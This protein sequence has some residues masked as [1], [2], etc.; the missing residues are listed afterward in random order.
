MPKW[1]LKTLRVNEN[2]TQEQ[3]AKKFGIS[4]SKVSNWEKGRTFPNVAELKKIEEFY[5]VDY[6]N[7]IFLPK[8]HG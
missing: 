3:F 7:I 1:T 4:V 8:E 5:G 2:L 6:H